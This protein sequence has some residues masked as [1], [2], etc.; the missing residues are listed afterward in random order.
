MG[1]LLLELDYRLKANRKT[2]EGKQHPDRD[3]QFKYIAQKSQEFLDAGDPVISVDT[4]K[5]EKVGNYKNGGREYEPKEHVEEV[6]THDF[7]QRDAK[8]RVICAIPYGVYEQERN[9]GWVSVGVD[10][11]TA[12]FA[13]ATIAQ[14]W[15][16]MGSSAYSESRRVMITVDSGG[17]NGYRRRAWKTEIQR[18]AD[19]TGLE[20]HVSHFP[21]GTSKW[22]K[23]E[24]RMFSQITL[25]WR[26][27]PLTSHETIVNLIANTKTEKG[28]R[29]E[30]TL[31]TSLYPIGIK[32]PQDEFDAMNIQTDDF[33][34]EWNYSILPS[35]R[36]NEKK[37]YRLFFGAP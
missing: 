13:V 28:L 21:P 25:N 19:T 29:I 11:D 34:P 27:R 14:W 15:E 8:G 17:S 10:H 36:K 26:G 24:H 7:G 32:I 6:E 9:V 1:R 20:F 33:H 5:K 23:I 22:N 35:E 30:A 3:E 31:D 37:S 12:H 2:Q 16:H 4:K 18:L